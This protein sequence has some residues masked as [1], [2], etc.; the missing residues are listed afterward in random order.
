MVHL[1]DTLEKM[2]D[3]LSIVA[4]GGILMSPQSA[5]A[6][7]AGLDFAADEAR[8]Q[9][10]ELDQLRWNDKARRDG[11]R[12]VTHAARAAAE[13]EGAEAQAACARVGER[14]HR[15]SRAD[16]SPLRQVATQI[17]TARP[18][19]VV[20]SRALTEGDVAAAINA[21]ADAVGVT[22]PIDA[23]EGDASPPRDPLHR[24]LKEDGA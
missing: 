14:L 16:A 23:L 10:A 9:E 20:I 8:R 17:K 13:V 4:G 12:N 6:F 1:S 11:L 21:I 7:L 2:R 3:T 19:V 18:S 24:D 5:Q 15:L 22:R